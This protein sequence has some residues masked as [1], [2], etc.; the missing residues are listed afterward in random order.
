MRKPFI[1][2]PT[3]VLIMLL[4]NISFAQD[5][6][7]DSLSWPTHTISGEIGGPAIIIGINY[8]FTFLKTKNTFTAVKIGTGTQLV[9][10]NSSHGIHV[11]IGRKLCF[12]TGAG[13]SVHAGVNLSLHSGG[14]TE[15]S[16]ML[17]ATSG[18][19]YQPFKEGLMFR[20][21]YIRLIQVDFSDSGSWF[22]I[23]AGWSL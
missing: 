5:V 6:K 4:I 3:P 7:K 18:L 21:S 10:F 2:L 23:G 16:Y 12:E 13:G 9:G 20:L 11:N 22:T 15:V 19:R 14:G 17:Y 8:E 1:I